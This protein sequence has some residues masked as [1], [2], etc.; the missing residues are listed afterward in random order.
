L[1]S[2]GRVTIDQVVERV[3]L[4]QGLEVAVSPLSGGLTNE[5]YLVEAGGAKYVVRIPGR[6][7]ELLAIDRANE[8]H[9][10]N[11]AAA[12]GVGPM[13][14]EHLPELDVMVLDFIPGVTM[15]GATLRSAE[16][17]RRMA[18]SIRR[19]H[20]GPRFLHDFDMYRLVEY[21]LGICDTNDVRIPDGF[22]GRMGTIAEVERAMLAHPLPTV[23]C[24]NDLLAENY[25]DDGRTLWLLDWE[26]SGN[27]D[28]TFELANTAQECEF[29]DELRWVLCEAYFGAAN[30]ALLARMHL[31][32]L[33][34]DMGWTLWA[35]IQEKISEIDYDFWA[36]AEERWARAVAIMDSPG[37]P[38]LLRDVATGR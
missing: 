14:L 15:S 1:S 4:W 28:P 35:A 17:A 34:S 7:T 22:R 5:N 6:S 23:P 38:G 10:A 8:H 19:L 13:V 32:A 36:W 25:I 33:M 18:A 29:D 16:M 20:A 30:E 31:N 9:N 37:L 11:G 21:Y 3:R 12:A 2:T 27:N 26:Y 24:H